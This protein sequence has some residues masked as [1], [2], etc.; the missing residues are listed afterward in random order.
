MSKAD[1]NHA[2]AIFGN[3]HW[4][5]EKGSE[6]VSMP[7]FKQVEAKFTPPPEPQQVKYPK[8]VSNA[9]NKE[10]KSFSQIELVNDK[11]KI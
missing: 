2:Q 4:M 9:E 11:V 10:I 6:V 1:M 8:L 7:N 3:I 5:E